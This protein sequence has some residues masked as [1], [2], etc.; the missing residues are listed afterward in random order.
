MVTFYNKIQNVVHKAKG[1]LDTI[2]LPENSSIIFD[3]DGT[4][5]DMYENPISPVIDLY[6]YAGQLGI[7]RFL[8]TARPLYE[9]NVI[10]TFKILNLYGINDFEF[11]CFMPLD[12]LNIKDYKIKSREYIMN[13]GYTTVMSVGDQEKTDVGLYGGIGII[14]PS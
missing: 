5:I 2:S 13:M 9:E 11:A 1:L 7:K 6:H 3:I 4:L 12:T 8:I 10:H 14:I